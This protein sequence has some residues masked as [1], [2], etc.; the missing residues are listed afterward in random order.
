M[1]ATISTALKAH[2]ASDATT[3]CHIW[4]CN[5]KD[6]TS[7]YFTDNTNDILFEGKLYLSASGFTSSNIDTTNALNVDNLEVTG[8]L[9]QP[10]ITEVD[11]LIGIWDTA[12]ITLREVNYNDLTMGARHLRTGSVG[13]IRTGRTNFTCELR[14]LMQALQQNLLEYYSP[15]C[16]AHLGDGRCKKSLVGLTATG[17]VTTAI[18]NRA[19]LDTSLVQTTAVV[20]KAIATVLPGVNPTP[21]L[22]P[23]WPLLQGITNEAHARVH[24]VGH[25]LSSGQQVSFSGVTGMTQING[26]TGTV[27]YIDAN[28]F[29]VNIDTTLGSLPYAPFFKVLGF[30]VYTGGGIVTLLPASEYYQNGLVTWLTGLNTGLKMEVK[31]YAIGSLE[32]F[33][34]MPY[35][36]AMGDTYTV[37]A[38]CDKQLSTCRDRFANVINF[39]GEPHL[40]GNDALM[41]HA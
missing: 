40:P 15:S 5:L 25:G 36:V 11:T 6:G 16:R 9:A 26:M 27:A 29:T 1:S 22:L 23:T 7:R 28:T 13:I 10:T 17:S 4:D 20:Q 32:L 19:W 30:G 2:Y 14:G 37:S 21:G 38:G 24:A 34:A 33:E 41:K 35:T 8:G 12:H 31:R 18:N 3:V 39:R